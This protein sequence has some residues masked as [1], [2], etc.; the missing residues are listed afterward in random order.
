ME[1]VV[2][3][4]TSTFEQ[5]P[6]Q[7]RYTMLTIHFR[8]FAA[9]GPLDPDR[10]ADLLDRANARARE[11]GMAGLCIRSEAPE[12]AGWRSTEKGLMP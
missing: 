7:A 10:A 4:L 12:T 1:A 11:L 9:I 8:G 3:L 6:I 2:Q 5:S